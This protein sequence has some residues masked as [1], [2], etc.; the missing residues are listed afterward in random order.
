MTRFIAADPLPS[1]AA[2]LIL[3]NGPGDGERERER[4]DWAGMAERDGHPEGTPSQSVGSCS[5]LVR[6]RE[7]CKR[8]ETQKPLSLLPLQPAQLPP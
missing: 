2:L 1:S 8:A 5:F 6:V 7:Y 3:A 4:E